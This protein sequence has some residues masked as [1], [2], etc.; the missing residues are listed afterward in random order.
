[1]KQSIFHAILLLSAILTA[2][3]PTRGDNAVSVATPTA[4]ISTAAPTP[5]AQPSTPTSIPVIFSAD[6]LEESIPFCAAADDDNG[7]TLDCNDNSVTIS[8]N[9]NRRG[10]DII[11]RRKIDFYQNGFRIDA[12]IT[13]NP[14]DQSR[15]DQNQ[16]GFYFLME[17][18]QRYAVRLE[19][20]F[21]NFEEWM[22]KNGKEKINAWN[23]AYAP[24]ILSAGQNNAI[25]LQCVPENCDVFANEI[26]IGRLPLPGNDNQFI[27]AGIFTASPWDEK[28]GSVTFEDLSIQALDITRLETQPFTLTDD[29][30][31]ENGTFSQTGLS[32]AFSDFEEDGFHFS[33]VIPYGYYAVKTGPALRN[34]SV[35]VTVDMEFLPGVPAT[36]YGGVICRASNEGMIMAVLRAD[37]TYTI[38]RDSIRRAFAMLATEPVETIAAGRSAHQLRL[39]CIDDTIALFIDGVE[40]ESF[41]D[42]KNW[43]KYGNNG[44][45][46]KAGGAAY[47]DAIIFSHLEIKEVR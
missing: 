15:L 18:G 6:M 3:S 29:L 26:L 27:A 4:A 46:T 8:Q 42:S 32:G 45:Y 22:L 44:L 25:S 24:Q 17:N 35:S 20:Q 28:F 12:D 16:A 2:C 47:S 43:I 13:S 9:E 39:D 37:A 10:T 38:Y 7:F 33:P 41:T 34:V 14:A 5:N 1:M 11:L 31:A 36:Q 30:T 40:V 19:G 21:F 23:Q